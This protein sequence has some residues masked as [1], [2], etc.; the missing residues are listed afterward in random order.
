[1]K[2]SLVLTLIGKD[3]PGLV[4]LLSK[5]VIAHDANWEES[6][7]SRLSGR[8]AGILR[9][10]VDSA[11]AGDLETSLRNLEDQGLKVIIERSDDLTDYENY[12]KLVLELVGNDR[13]GIIHEISQVLSGHGINVKELHTKCESAPMIGDMLFKMK[14]SLQCPNSLDTEELRVLLEEL[15]NDLM[16]DIT[17]DEMRDD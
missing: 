12:Q 6:R 2:T 8:F 14:A 11:I 13:P 10:S 15:A 5:T 3:R 9:V 1:M 7:M 16:V 4:E 17:L